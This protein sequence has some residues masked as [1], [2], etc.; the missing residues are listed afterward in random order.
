MNDLR[1]HS[2]QEK[3]CFCSFT[4]INH[5]LAQEEKKKR[6][7][8]IIIGVFAFLFLTGSIVMIASNLRIHPATFIMGGVGVI[9][10]IVLIILFRQFKSN[11]LSPEMYLRNLVPQFEDQGQ[12]FEKPQEQDQDKC[13]LDNLT[14]NMSLKAK[15]KFLNCLDENCQLTKIPLFQNA[16]D[17][18]K[19]EIELEKGFER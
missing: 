5:R 8:K 1:I 7:T 16:K 13:E 14:L 3:S 4:A 11:R 19:D 6:I 15:Q 17:I 18:V 10:G 2:S 12:R 9:L